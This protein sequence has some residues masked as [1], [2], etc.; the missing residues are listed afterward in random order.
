MDDEQK[1]KLEKELQFL[2]DSMS[3]GIISQEEFNR[4]ESRIQA[5]LNDTGENVVEETTEEIPEEVEED[6][7]TGEVEEETTESEKIVGDVVEETIEHDEDDTD[8]SLEET[9]SKD[10]TTEETPLE[11]EASEEPVGEVVAEATL[12]DA[13]DQEVD[14]E[15]SKDADEETTEE[16]ASDLDETPVK[17][18]VV[19][20]AVVEDSKASEDDVPISDEKVTPVYDAKDSSER[21]S[22][23]KYAF[24]VLIIAF[25][26]F[27]LF[28]GNPFGDRSGS[29][30][31]PIDL[32]A[33]SQEEIEPACH[34][35]NDCVAERMI[36][37]C[38]DAG[39]EDAE[40][41]FI[42]D[43]EVHL[44]IVEDAACSLCDSTRME[45]T[46][47]E[48]FPNLVVDRLSFA[49]VEGR[50]LALRQQIPVLPAYFLDEK[51]GNAAH[52][53]LFARALSLVDGGYFV[54]P[55]A[56]GSPYFALRVTAAKTLTV[57]VTSDVR[58]RTLRNVQPVV[59]L[60]GE[61]IIFTERLVDVRSKESL[62]DDFA[63]STYPTFIINNNVKF[64]GIHSPDSIKE[65]YCLFNTHAQCSTPLT[66]QIS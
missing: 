42:A 12:E 25:G 46:L 41:R 5:Q 43:A 13:K 56:S 22:L 66:S 21:S 31:Q 34:R 30:D 23:G 40:C 51:V 50:G 32:L 48:V 2:K 45:Q 3:S 26:L 55:Q 24:I 17:E 59:N 44:T 29:M 9:P 11:E 6:T 63:I 53:D 36:G 19:V 28:K 65:N 18:A 60:F 10:E 62:V 49:S 33:H 54:T 52:F 61:D 39:T 27:F 1:E 38:A 16:Q 7:E 35:D 14:E 20:E 57:F 8:E 47:R 58:E 4:G 15:V 64:G 37:S